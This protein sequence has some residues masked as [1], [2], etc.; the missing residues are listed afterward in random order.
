MKVWLVGARGMLGTALLQRLER[1]AVP[2]VTTDRET[3]IGERATVLEFAAR[4]RPALIV[5]AAA[6]TK[7]DDA[8]S[9]EPEALRVNG[10]GPG[11]LGEAARAIG[12]DV[13]HFSTDYVFDG[14]AR[15]PYGED[16]PTGPAGAYG[17]SKL[18]GERRLLAACSSRA[19]IIRTSWLFGE[20]GPSFVR[21]MMRLVAEKEEVRVVVDQ[22]GRPTYT[23][24]LADA[25]LALAGLGGRSKAPPGLY[26]FANRGELSWHAFTLE[27]R[28]ACRRRGLPLRAERVVPVTTAEF[29]RPAPRPAYSV[30][31]TT[32]IERA[33]GSAPRHF[34]EA[35]D[36]FIEN[37]TDAGARGS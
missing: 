30:L 4:E 20:N 27:I 21:T 19:T 36:E 32:R 18:E 14:K 9:Q 16:A 25:A 15:E 13:T 23:R 10:A 8:E 28:D 5:N 24:D 37:E 33:L 26:H 2:V 12:A 1:L 29:P 11:N 6:Y 35:L 17:R 34:R 31:D 3:D 7:V 22:E